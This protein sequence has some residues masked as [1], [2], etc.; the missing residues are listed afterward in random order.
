MAECDV[1][2]VDSVAVRRAMAGPSI[3]SGVGGGTIGNEYIL[4]IYVSGHVLWVGLY[5]GFE[6]PD[7]SCL[8]SW[9][10]ALLICSLS[11]SLDS[12][13]SSSIALHCGRLQEEADTYISP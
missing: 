2:R 3:G 12:S 10:V 11:H 1:V 4:C 7:K 5:V 9:E 13:S 8:S 6:V